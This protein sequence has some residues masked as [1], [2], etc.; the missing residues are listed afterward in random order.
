M[1][2]SANL[3]RARADEID[4]SRVRKN[5]TQF[6]SHIRHITHGC[7]LRAVLC[8]YHSFMYQP[9][10]E[11][12]SKCECE[13]VHA[14]FIWLTARRLIHALQ[15]SG[16]GSTCSMMII[17]LSSSAHMQART[18]PGYNSN[19]NDAK[20]LAARARARVRKWMGSYDATAKAD[21]V[22][23]RRMRKRSNHQSP[24][25]VIRTAQLSRNYCRLQ[26]AK[27]QAATT[28]K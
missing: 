1:C 22:S 8:K 24:Q 25:P 7:V 17:M 14:C 2:A 21:G 10:N 19:G 23:S 18:P 26:M 6:A 16:T 5:K 12:E 28:E 15:R 11:G 20:A 13:R 4:A 27:S 9:A 3:N